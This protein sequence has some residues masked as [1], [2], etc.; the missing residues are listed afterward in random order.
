MLTRV[1]AL[2]GT[3]IGAASSLVMVP[4]AVASEI[5]AFVALDSV[6]VKVSSGSTIES[7]T[8][9]TVF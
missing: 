2:S 5:V 1:S 3:S 4:F 7:L 9:L 6:T 8:V